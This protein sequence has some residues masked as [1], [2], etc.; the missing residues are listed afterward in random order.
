M[1]TVLLDEDEEGA[2]ASTSKQA[3]T[4]SKAA[5]Q[6]ESRDEPMSCWPDC[7]CNLVNQK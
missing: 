6:K 1:S 4:Y 2:A 7:R 3:G 5:F